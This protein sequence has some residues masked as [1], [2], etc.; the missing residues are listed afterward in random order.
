MKIS[1]KNKNSLP[2]V[3]TF[4]CRLNSYESEIIE[5]DLIKKGVENIA[6]YNSC[7]VTEEAIRQ[8]KYSIR[9][10]RR[11]EPNTKIIV[12]GKFP[13]NCPATPGQNN[14]GKNAHKVVAVDE[15]MGQNILFAAAE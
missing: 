15:I 14:I 9:K 6:V 4:G 1:S 12:T 2:D 13:I 7:A 10:K 11:D 3:K 5:Q 8:V